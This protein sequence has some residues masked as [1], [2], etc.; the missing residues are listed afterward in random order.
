M[1][2]LSTACTNSIADI[3]SNYGKQDVI[4]VS[5]LCEQYGIDIDKVFV[6]YRGRTLLN[7]EKLR[8]HDDDWAILS[9]TSGG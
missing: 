7:N 2:V 9:R 4:S 8:V 5:D 6:V 3:K 1:Q